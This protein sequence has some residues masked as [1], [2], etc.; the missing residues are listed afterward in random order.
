MY[1]L[2]SPAKKLAEPTR[3]HQNA[4]LP[5]FLDDAQELVDTMKKKAPADLQT[6]MGISDALATLNVERFQAFETPFTQANAS[7]AALTF[8]GDTYVG[9]DASTLTDDD[10]AYAQ[11]RIGILSGL[12]GL[13]RPLD[14]MQPYR[15][16]MGTKLSTSRGKNLYEFWD[17]KVT[18]QINGHLAQLDRPAVINL[19]SK[20]YFSVLRQPLLNAPVITPVFKDVRKGKAKVIS[21]LAKRARGAMARFIVKNRLTEPSALKDFTGDGYRYDENSSAETEWVFIRPES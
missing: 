1:A 4:S 13:L 19:A 12:F 7:L 11:T 14:L 6:L 8:S 5:H 17:R 2:L 16:E 18:D 3:F 9:F 21:F 10:L 15:L 20:E